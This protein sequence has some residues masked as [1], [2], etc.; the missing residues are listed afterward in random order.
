L[1]QK[2]GYWY[3]NEVFFESNTWD[4]THSDLT[5]TDEVIWSAIDEYKSV[6]NKDTVWH[7][8]TK[9]GEAVLVNNDRN[10]GLM[11]GAAEYSEIPQETRHITRYFLGSTR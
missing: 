7:S 4:Y 1:L 8:A 6:W 10:I 11:H 2:D 5:I 9:L 3:P